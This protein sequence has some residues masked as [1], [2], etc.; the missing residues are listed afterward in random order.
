MTWKAP[1]RGGSVS[2]LQNVG[3]IIRQLLARFHI[4]NGFDPDPAVV[5]DRIA[6]RVAGVVDEPRL[7]SV[8]GCIDHDVVIDS[9]EIRVVTIPFIVPERHTPAVKKRF[10]CICGAETCRGTMLGRKR[11]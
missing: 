11:R 2:F 1:L 9:E 4:P 6:V 10:P 7:V 5:D 3:V 8:D